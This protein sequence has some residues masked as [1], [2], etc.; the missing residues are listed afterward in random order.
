MRTIAKE[1]ALQIAMRNCSKEA[2]GCGGQYICDFGEGEVHAIKH[3]IFLQKVPA[4]SKK[5][6]SP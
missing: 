6:V 4:S 1:T 5:Q 3:I 2:R